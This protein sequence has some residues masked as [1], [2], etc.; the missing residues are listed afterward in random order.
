M[1]EKLRTTKLSPLKK[2]KRKVGYGTTTQEPAE[3]T[4]LQLKR[5]RIQESGENEGVDASSHLG[6]EGHAVVW[7]VRFLSVFLYILLYYF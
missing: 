7:Q 4:R 2:V 5:M 1:L 6:G 3:E